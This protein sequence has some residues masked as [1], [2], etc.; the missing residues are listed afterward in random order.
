[1]K[2]LLLTLS[3]TIALGL[4]A[5]AQRDSFFTCNANDEDDVYRNIEDGFTLP[6]AHGT[7]DDYNSVPVGSGLLILTALGAGYMV[8]RHRK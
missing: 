7:G 4:C 1:M 5:N 6:N 8:S 2:K 3:L